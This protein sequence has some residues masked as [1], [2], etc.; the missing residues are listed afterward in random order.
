MLRLNEADGGGT[1]DTRRGLLFFCKAPFSGEPKATAERITRLHGIPSAV[2]FGLPLNGGYGG[3]HGHGGPTAGTDR[4]P[5]RLV[6]RRRRQ[7]GRCDAVRAKDARL[8]G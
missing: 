8:D 1:T 3:F 2:T 7:S 4:S 6:L 5:G